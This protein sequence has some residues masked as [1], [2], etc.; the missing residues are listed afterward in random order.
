MS[1]SQ[2]P[3]TL[4]ITAGCAHSRTSLAP[5]LWASTT[6]ESEGLLDANRRATAT[7]AGES[8][9]APTY[10]KHDNVVNVDR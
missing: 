6:W 7:R 9:H 3:A 10:G 1:E 5:A 4:A 2:Q 8:G